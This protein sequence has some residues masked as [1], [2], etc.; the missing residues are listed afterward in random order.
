MNRIVRV[1]LQGLL[2]HL[3]AAQVQQDVLGLV[4]QVGLLQVLPAY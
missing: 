4:L 2:I 1:N 3:M